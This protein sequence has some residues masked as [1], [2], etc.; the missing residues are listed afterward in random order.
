VAYPKLIIRA[1]K[2]PA[3]RRIVRGK[4]LRLARLP[5]V[6]LNHRSLKS[7]DVLF[8]SYP[9]SGN[10]WIKFMLGQII[11]G[12]EV[13]FDSVDRVIP[14]LGDDMPP[15]G[16]LP[17]G[18]RLIKTH[19]PFRGI[20]APYVK[21]AVVLVRDGRDVALSYYRSQL[22]RGWF[23]GS[24]A[25]APLRRCS[26]GSGEGDRSRDRISRPQRR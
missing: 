25:F 13:D 11:T 5:G 3:V 12:R 16:P 26:R 20:T 17:N 9:K 23:E 1:S 18:G 14:Y 22:R 4:G 8:A 6:I 24:H 19:E 15:V 21:K 2:S 10:T 7:S